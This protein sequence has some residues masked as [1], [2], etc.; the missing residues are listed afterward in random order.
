M[1][2]LLYLCCGAAYGVATLHVVTKS[3]YD[4][5]VVFAH[6]LEFSDYQLVVC[7]F[8]PW[9]LV[10]VTTSFADSYRLGQRWLMST[11]RHVGY[12]LPLWQLHVVAI[13]AV[14]D[15]PLAS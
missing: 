12:R 3:W 10:A 14:A 4:L 11:W 6:F 1:Y 8:L 15:L 5:Y 9:L 7:C 2:K 13:L